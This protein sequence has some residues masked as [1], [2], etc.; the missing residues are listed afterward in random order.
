MSSLYN[1][2]PNPTAKVILKTTAGDLAL[3][4]FAKQ[5][6]LASRNFLQLCL[7]GYYNDTIFHRLVPEFI[8]QGGDPTGTGSGGESCYDAGAPFADEFHSRLRF[9][10]RGLLGMANSGTKDD[11]GSQFFLTLGKAEELNGRNT[12]FGRIEG[13]TIYNLVKMGEAELMEGEGSER[14]MYPSRVTGSEILV[15]PFEDMVK[16]A[17]TAPVE[18]AAKN[19][20]KKK[21]RKKP[22]KQMLSFG[23]EEG[24]GVDTQ[25][26]QK[27]KF[28]PKL[29]QSSDSTPISNKVS[30]S[31]KRASV[32]TNAATSNKQDSTKASHTFENPQQRNLPERSTHISKDEPKDAMDT[33]SSESEEV[34]ESSKLEKT[35]AQIENLKQSLKRQNPA[36]VAHEAKRQ[37]STLESLMPVGAKRGVKLKSGGKVEQRD[38]DEFEAFQARIKGVDDS[39]TRLNGTG[40][41]RKDRT[42]METVDDQDSGAAGGEEEEDVCD[43]HFVPNCQSCKKWDEAEENLNDEQLTSGSLM[44]HKLTFAKDRLG[45]DLEWKRQNEKE[46]VVIDP[47]EREKELL[48]SLKSKTKSKR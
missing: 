27:P 7:D 28:N 44:G 11:N 34:E 40:Q 10:R 33:S 3:E 39:T 19:E 18:P 30:A 42:S 48:G 24:E 31:P 16:R 9:N 13:D 23:G 47:R 43:L 38:L 26:V 22:G 32:Q 8:I 14:P 36:P 17:R 2:E 29:V 46:L 21:P 45:K 1:V 12:M 15:N 37:R 6:P 4:I 5:T 35:N 41:A 20:P 25:M